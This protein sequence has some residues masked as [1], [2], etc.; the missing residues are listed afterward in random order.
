MKNV[1]IPCSRKY[2]SRDAP[3]PASTSYS[4]PR[5]S[6]VALSSAC[7]QIIFQGHQFESVQEQQ[8]QQKYQQQEFT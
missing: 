1:S 2:E 6:S 4:P 3:K 7:K 5:Q 8:Q